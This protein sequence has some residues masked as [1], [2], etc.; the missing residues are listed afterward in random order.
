MEIKKILCPID[1]SDISQSGFN[2]AV[3]MA[4][5]HKAELTVLHVIDQLHGLGGYQVLALDLGEISQQME[6]DASAKLSDLLSQVKENIKIEKAV[7]SGK[8]SSQIIKM[9]KD[10][11]ADLIIMASHG[12]TGIPHVIMGSVAETVV[13]HAECPVLVVRDI[14]R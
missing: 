3:F 10:I 7:R 4:H 2:Y 1:F 12:R 11:K 6:K 9:A 8:A 14:L 5:S 13:R